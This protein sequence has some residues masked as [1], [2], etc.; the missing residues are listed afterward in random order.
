MKRIEQAVCSISNS[1]RDLQ[2]G[3]IHFNDIK[4][5]EAFL[6]RRHNSPQ[7]LQKK[8]ISHWTIPGPPRAERDVVLPFLPSRSSQADPWRDS[9]FH[10]W[11]AIDNVAEHVQKT[12]EVVRRRRRRAEE[13]VVASSPLDFPLCHP[14]HRC[15]R[16]VGGCSSP[17]YE[18]RF[19]GDWILRSHAATTLHALIA[20]FATVLLRAAYH[21]YDL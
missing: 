13:G 2:E 18:E 3:Q 4:K 14:Y 21:L 5:I 10:K 12:D 1:F 6:T 16:N 19:I 7:V 8:R 20:P 15:H 11:V 17:V 9:F